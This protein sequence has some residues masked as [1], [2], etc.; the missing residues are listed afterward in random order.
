MHIF[1]TYI[2]YTRICMYTGYS[3]VSSAYALAA[4]PHGALPLTVRGGPV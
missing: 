2:I 1:P 4:Y 3:S